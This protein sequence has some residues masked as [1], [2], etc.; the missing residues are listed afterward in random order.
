[1]STVNFHIDGQEVAVTQGQSVLVGA[2]QLG[3]DIP[4]LC[5]L[6]KCGPLTTC[7]VGDEDLGSMG[8]PIS[9]VHDGREIK[10]CCK[11]C[12]PQFRKEPQTFM[13]KLDDAAKKLPAK[14]AKPAGHEH[15]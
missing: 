9:F 12:E 5:H 13:K 10:L 14:L 11:A 6:E 8:K 3:I 2:R 7:L 1:M 15:H 4:T